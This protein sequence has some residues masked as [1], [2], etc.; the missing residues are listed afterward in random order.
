MNA[1]QRFA[2]ARRL[3]QTDRS[4]RERIYAALDDMTADQM[5]CGARLV[6][7]VEGYGLP[8]A[9]PIEPEPIEI[10]LSM[11]ANADNVKVTVEA[12]R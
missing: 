8:V 6:K 2:H 1:A 3:P 7:H 5:T 4:R 12:T 11:T 9:E 10:N